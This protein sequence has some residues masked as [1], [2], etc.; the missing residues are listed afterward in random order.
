VRD[1]QRLFQFKGSAAPSHHGARLDGLSRRI[2]DAERALAAARPD[3]WRWSRELAR[4][5][6]EATDVVSALRALR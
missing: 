2:D 3:Y 6:D 1:A 5:R 4:I